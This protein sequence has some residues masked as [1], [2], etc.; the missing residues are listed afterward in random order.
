LRRWNWPFQF[1]KETLV[2]VADQFQRQ[3]R[4]IPPPP[5]QTWLRLA[6]SYFALDIDLDVMLFLM[7]NVFRDWELSEYFACGLATIR[8][9][10]YALGVRKPGWT[11]TSDSE[12][13]EVHLL[14]DV[15]FH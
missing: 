12:L 15:L 7:E 2:A 9:R 6:D 13:S 1:I 3:G 5:G 14:P 11:A 10:R 8:T 4:S